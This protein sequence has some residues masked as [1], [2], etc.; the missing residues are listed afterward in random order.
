MTLKKKGGWNIKI[1]CH[2]NEIKI[3]NNK[4]E[5]KNKNWG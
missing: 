5:G 1:G 4:R 2:E 3:K